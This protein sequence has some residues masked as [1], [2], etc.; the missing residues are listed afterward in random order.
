MARHFGPSDRY[1]EDIQILDGA[2]TRGSIRRITEDKQP[3][4][5]FSNEKTILRVRRDSLIQTAQVVQRVNTGQLYLTA[6]HTE[7]GDYRVHRL[8]RCS[9]Q[10]LW[11]RKQTVIDP[12]SRREVADDSPPTELGNIHVMW[13]IVRREN[14]DFVMQ[15]AEQRSLVATNEDIQLGDWLDGQEVKRLN[16][17]LG[18]KIAEVQ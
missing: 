11:T 6:D 3:N 13:D 18:I 4:F 12:V 7:T 17:A 8:L 9:R 5:E 10:V 16:T 2:R 1:Q 14:P 15:V